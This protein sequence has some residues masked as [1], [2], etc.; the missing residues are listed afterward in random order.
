MSTE[1]TF[2]GVRG[3]TPCSS[4]AHQRYGGNTS[5]VVLERPGRE[6]LVFDLGTGLRFFGLH[7]PHPEPF[8]A[9]A[10][11]SH[12]HWDHVQGIPFFAPL[13]T[14]G[15]HLDLYGPA[16]P[17]G[18]LEQVIKSFLTPP[19]FPVE[20]DSLPCSISFHDISP[21]SFDVDG[22]A[23]TA[24]M[25][26]H[27]GPTLGFRVEID[28]L[29]VAYVSDH[30]QP[31]PGSRWVAP[32]VLEL[33]AGVDVLIHDAQFDDLEFE[34]RSDWGHCTVD[35]AVEVAVQSGARTLA[36]FHHDPSH[37]DAHIDELLDGARNRAA[38]SS[39]VEVIAAHEGLTI[40]LDRETADS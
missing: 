34:M 36:L 25:V 26:P 7:R 24:A 4:D 39:S 12:L 13:L 9:S 23:V 6:P 27:V 8:R 1:V 20:L 22:A 19:Y 16:Q 31:G 11:V 40:A 29:S 3:S 32:E 35:Y 14:E 17:D 37:S 10:L 18:S 5:C 15:A 2:F 28:G 21:G 38:E 30:Q 33:C